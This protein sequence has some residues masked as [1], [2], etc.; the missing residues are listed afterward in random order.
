[1]DDEEI[2]ARLAAHRAAISAVAMVLNEVAPGTFSN[3]IEGL[4]TFEELCDLRMG[5]EAMKGSLPQT[6]PQPP[7]DTD[8]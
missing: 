5:L 1:M 3:V 6:T 8:R 4:A 7:D 2:L